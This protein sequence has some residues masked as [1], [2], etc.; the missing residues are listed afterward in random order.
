MPIILDETPDVSIHTVWFFSF[1]FWLIYLCILDWYCF[2]FFF[3][4]NN[5]RIWTS[6]FI[7]GMW[8]SRICRT[9]SWTSITYFNCFVRRWWWWWWWWRRWW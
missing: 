4:A 1:F 8:N 3:T 9:K 5:H 2:F 7:T 6:I